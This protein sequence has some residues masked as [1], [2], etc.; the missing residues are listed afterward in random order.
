MCHRTTFINTVNS[1]FSLLL[2]FTWNI[3]F[4]YRLEFTRYRRRKTYHREMHYEIHT[5]PTLICSLKRSKL[6]SLRDISAS[7]RK[8]EEEDKAEQHH[9]QHLGLAPHSTDASVWILGYVTGILGWLL[10]ISG[11]ADKLQAAC[12]HMFTC[13][14][15][16]YQ[17]LKCWANAGTALCH[18]L[19]PPGCWQWLVNHCAAE[20]GT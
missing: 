20:T 5:P 15:N 13:Q 19:A 14:T 18:I 1:F 12:W 8:L 11:S 6:S 2:F 9:A 10:S 4:S 16:P 3:Q 17:S 7:E